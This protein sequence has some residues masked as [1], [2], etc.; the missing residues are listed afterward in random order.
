MTMDSVRAPLPPWSHDCEACRRTD[1][2][3]FTG[4]PSGTAH[5]GWC[6]FEWT[7]HQ[8]AHCP[9]C[10]AHFTSYSASDEHEGEG[11]CLDP[12]TVPSL[13]L[14]ADGVTWRL[15]DQSRLPRRP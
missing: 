11:G 1:V 7:S 13:A 5:C 9:A 3:G 8:A 15:A 6:H 12:A 4:L 2:E 10:C 14:A